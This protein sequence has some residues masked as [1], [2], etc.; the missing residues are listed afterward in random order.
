MLMLEPNPTPYDLRWRMFGI[1]VRVH[2]MFWLISTILGWS[3]FGLGDS[4]AEGLGF[5]ALWVGCVFL[6]VLI[7]ELGHVVA[8]RIF[9][10]SGHI[11]LFSFGGLAIGSSDVPRRWQRICVY[12]A[13]PGAQFL[14][15]GL[16]WLLWDPIRRTVAPTAFFRPV[17]VLL[18]MLWIINLFWPILNL[19]PI[20]PLDGG[21][22]SRELCEGTWRANGRR[23]SLIISMVTA[24]VLALHIILSQNG[25]PGLIPILNEWFPFTPGLLTAIFFGLF[26]MQ[27]FQ[28]LQEES[29]RRRNWDDDR[30]PWER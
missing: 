20:W 11:V 25:K 5:V 23:Y 30:L 24:I 6:S 19:L 7:H 8:G 27:S 4:G 14:L 16:L 3:W 2:P 28:A 22:V 1:P 12:L 21:Q 15:L 13:G 9:G 17:A 18:F 26:A 10:S 29:H